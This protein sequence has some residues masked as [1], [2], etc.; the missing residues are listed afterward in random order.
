MIQGLNS[1]VQHDGVVYHVQTQD[2]GTGAS[3]VVTMIYKGGAIVSSK[4]TDYSGFAQE[5][6]LAARVRE[7][8]ESQHRDTIGALKAGDIDLSGIERGA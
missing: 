2:L 3:Q 8:V 1:N 5:A 7:L 4:K 6:D